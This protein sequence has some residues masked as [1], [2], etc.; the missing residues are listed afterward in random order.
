MT[1]VTPAPE[2]E[3]LDIGANLTHDSFDADRDD[4]MARA[5]A[6]GVSRFVVTGSDAAHSHQALAL[7]RRYPGQ[8]FATAGVHPHHA[9]GYAADTTA[10]LHNLLAHPEVV[11]VGECGLDYFR[12][13][14]PPEVQRR[15]FEQQLEL[16]CATGKPA[17]L[18]Q[19]DAHVD[20]MHILKRYRP[21][22]GRAVVHCFTGT[23]AELRDYLDL[24]CYIGITGW[25][26]DERRGLHLRECIPLIP[27][28][29]LMIETDSPYLIPRDLKPR[30]T[31]HRNEPMYLKHICTVVA[32]AAGRPATQ[33]AA[34][35]VANA[36]GFFAL[37]AR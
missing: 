6:M 1:D 31:S 34:E 18:H 11:A 19:R 25:I 2:F 33:L 14:S 12:N 35:T 23:A 4:V 29:R 28:G 21:R 15:V 26:C 5:R 16:A 20:F 22:F 7:S 24:D 10:E 30:P 9:K 27:T 32:A 17:F 36:V 13:F 3:L 8:V 37:P